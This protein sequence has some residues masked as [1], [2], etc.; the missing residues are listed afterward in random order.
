MPEAA[1]VIGWVGRLVPIKGLP[2]LIEALALLPPAL[3][4][5]RLLLVGDGSER[6]RLEALAQ[7]LGVADRVE[8]AGHVDDPAALY[9]R[10]SLFALPSLHEGVPLALLEAMAAGVPCVAAAVGGIPE[11]AGDHGAIRLVESRAAAD[12]ADAFR[13]VLTDPAAAA[14]LG[15]AGRER[16]AERYSLDAVVD[17]YLAL[18][19]EALGSGRLS[20]ASA[21]ARA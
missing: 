11:M 4:N 2:V 20:P 7:R 5:A 9:P 15:A 8:L 17:A 21:R 10:M 3:G 13:S 16:V 18:Y 1:P 19:R 14:R 12:W 6:A